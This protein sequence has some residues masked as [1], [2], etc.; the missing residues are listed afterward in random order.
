M[1]LASLGSG[2]KGNCTVLRNG[3]TNV[4]IDCG[5]SLSQ[6]EKRL[7]RL[8]LSGADIDAILVTHEHS[9][10][11]CGVNRAA[12]KYQIPVYLTMGSARQLE[13]GEFNI[14]SGGQRFELGD[15]GIQVVTVPHDAAEPVQFIF[16]DKHTQTRFGILTDSGHVTRHMITA[17]QDLKGLLLEF[18][19]DPEMLVAGPYPASLKQRVAGD[20]GH[21]SNAQSMGMLEQ[22]NAPKLDCLIAAHISEKNNSPDLVSSLLQT[23]QMDVDPVLA[24]Q[25]DGFDWIQI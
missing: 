7:Q 15:L 6:F 20:H 11:G 1:Q 8:S 2:S 14:I 23:L 21:L 17:Y 12:K 5:F 3:G 10:H 25:Q 22:I 19:Y 18:N 24:T 4:V 16:T 9:D 13:L